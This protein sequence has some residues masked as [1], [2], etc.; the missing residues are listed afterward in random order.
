MDD[1]VVVKKSSCGLGL[2]REMMAKILDHVYNF[3]KETQSNTIL[4][5]FRTDLDRKYHLFK[6]AKCFIC[7]GNIRIKNRLLPSGEHALEL[8]R[9]LV[10][11]SSLP[12]SSGNRMLNLP[13]D[14][15]MKHISS[16]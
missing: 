11:A 4:T 12:S 15:E 1:P 14:S 9:L 7:L 2:E 10:R 16:L 5:V 13:E 3:V 8:P 6:Q